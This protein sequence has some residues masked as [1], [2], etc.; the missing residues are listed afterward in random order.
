VTKGCGTDKKTTVPGRGRRTKRAGLE[1]ER[2][3][4]MS[5]ISHRF[6]SMVDLA[7]RETRRQSVDA[8]KTAPV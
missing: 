6:Q 1:Q 3:A 5:A 2:T 7:R 4:W 8:Q